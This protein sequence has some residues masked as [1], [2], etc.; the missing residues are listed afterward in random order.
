M[1]CYKVLLLISCF[2]LAKGHETSDSGADPKL[3]YIMAELGQLKAAYKDTQVQFGHL[4]T[5]FKVQ[6]KELD[7]LK[8]T[9]VQLGQL[10][11]AYQEQQKTLESVQKDLDTF[12]ARY[13]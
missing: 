7:R 13:F 5:A 11:T 1:E 6:Q 2:C 4:Q 3:E 8:D 10:E 12:Q 9:K